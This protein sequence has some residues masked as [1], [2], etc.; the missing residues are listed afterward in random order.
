MASVP[1]SSK[2]APHPEVSGQHAQ[3]QR[4]GSLGLGHWRWVALAPYC[5]RSGVDVLP[6]SS[7]RLPAEQSLC[8]AVCSTF[9][10]QVTNASHPQQATST[11]HRSYRGQ[12][13]FWY[14]VSGAPVANATNRAAVNR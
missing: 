8:P 6:W 14:V 10:C 7:A 2:L 9:A 5:T 1:S 3:R 11:P 12:R 4:I 13:A